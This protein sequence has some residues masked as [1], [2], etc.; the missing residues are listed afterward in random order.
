MLAGGPYDPA[1]P[2]LVAARAAAQAALIEFGNEPEEGRRMEIIGGII[3]SMGQDCLIV[4]PFFCDYGTYVLL[5]EDVFV[6]TRC[7]FLDCAEICIGDHTQFGP[8]AQVLAADHP[9]DPAR[10]LDD[11]EL[12]SPVTIGSNCWIGAGA[13]VCPGVSIGDDTVIGAGSVV[14]R[15]VPSRVVAAGN[16]CRVIREL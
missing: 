16:P 13:I 7:V 14:V 1:D 9:R 4:P 6:N 10:R 15:D 12:T 5:G 2:E 3:G 11:G 8:G